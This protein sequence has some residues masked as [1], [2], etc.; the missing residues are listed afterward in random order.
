LLRP[1]RQDADARRATSEAIRS[2]FAPFLVEDDRE[3]ALRA[4]ALGAVLATRRLLHARRFAPSLA[5][6][7]QKIG[8]DSLLSLRKT[9]SALRNIHAAR[10]FL[11][12]SRNRGV[13]DTA[14]SSTVPAV[15]L[16]DLNAPQRGEKVHE[17]KI[18]PTFFE[19]VLAGSK[20]FEIRKDDRGFSVGDTLKLC[21]WDPD[22]KKHTGRFCFRRVTCITDGKAIDAKDEGVLKD[23]YVVLGLGRVL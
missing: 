15:E 17:L 21:E 3:A 16:I 10:A 5:G 22:K 19:Q 4:H 12:H 1:A 8:R 14:K 9:R 20:P 7:K 13:T 11:G 18:W 2:Y 23:G 6:R